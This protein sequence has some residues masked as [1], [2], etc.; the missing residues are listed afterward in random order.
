M[1]KEAVPGFASS[2]KEGTTAQEYA[3][4]ALTLAAADGAYTTV[5]LDGAKCSFV[6]ALESIP[7][8]GYLGKEN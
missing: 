5:P 3:D 6:F 8:A 4:G 1:V 2:G 7:T